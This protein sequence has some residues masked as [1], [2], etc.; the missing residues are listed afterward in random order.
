MTDAMTAIVECDFEL[1]ESL[2]FTLTPAT[3]TEI[4]DMYHH[5]ND[6]S[7]RD[8][9][10]HLLQDCDPARVQSVMQNALNSPT[11]ESR[12]IAYCSLCGD[13][14]AF[15]SFLRDGFVDADLVD[16]AIRTKFGS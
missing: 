1:A 10:V 13:F 4:V 6:W 3:I 2:R 15:D 9:A 8:I 14:E 7:R 11:P 16:T 12:A 5:L